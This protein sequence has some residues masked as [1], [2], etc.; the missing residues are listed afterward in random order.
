MPTLPGSRHTSRLSERAVPQLA[1]PRAVVVVVV[2][3]IADVPNLLNVSPALHCSPCQALCTGSPTLPTGCRPIQSHHHVML[4][5]MGA[6]FRVIQAERGRGQCWARTGNKIS[7]SSHER[8]RGGGVFCAASKWHLQIATTTFQTTELT[9][10]LQPECLA[11]T[12]TAII[13]QRAPVR[14]QPPPPPLLAAAHQG[15]LMFWHWRE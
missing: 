14:Q 11:A 12:A 3:V 7:I 13:H 15:R 5:A 2:V 6:G 9:D 1:G 10:G 4:I 8:G